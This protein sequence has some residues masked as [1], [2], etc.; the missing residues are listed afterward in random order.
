MIITSLHFKRSVLHTVVNKH[1]ILFLPP[2][3]PPPSPSPPPPPVNCSLGAASVPIGRTVHRLVERKEPVRAADICFVVSMTRS[4]QHRWIQIIATTVDS[5]LKERG[6]GNNTSDGS[7]NRFCLIRFGGRTHDIY[8][9]FIK[10]GNSTFFSSSSAQLARKKLSKHGFVADGYE[11]LEFAIKNT[12]FRTDPDVARSFILG[13]DT[14]RT[15]LADKAYLNHM[16]LSHWLQER[17]ITLDV[18]VNISLEVEGMEN[19]TVLGMQSLK[20]ASVLNGET[21]ENVRG[22][23]LVKDSHGTTLRD[24]VSLAFETGGAVWPIGNMK[25]PPFAAVRTVAAAYVESRS[26]LQAQVCESCS[27]TRVHG[28]ES[29]HCSQP[30]SYIGCRVC[31][32]H[33]TEEVS[34]STLL[35][36]G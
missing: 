15:V 3:P 19:H 23:V 4:M 6:I 31:V 22:T 28:G 34:P 29:L 8:A 1:Y 2:P 32:N 33:T 5:L 26:Y 18:A 27:C 20:E 11:A 24:Y 35:T 12:P 25:G 36:H 13:T 14:G 16:L 17:D 10:V 21:V 9:E 30:S 7:V